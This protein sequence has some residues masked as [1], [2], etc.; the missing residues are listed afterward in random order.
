MPVEL[1][2]AEIERILGAASQSQCVTTQS[3]IERLSNIFSPKPDE[4]NSWSVVGAVLSDSVTTR[5]TTRTS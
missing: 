3:F 1:N 4:G 2:K 5:P